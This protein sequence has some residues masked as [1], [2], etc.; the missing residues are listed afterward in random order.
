MYQIDR[1]ARTGAACGNPFIA[2]YASDRSRRRCGEAT[3]SSQCCMLLGPLPM[4]TA[5]VTEPAATRPIHERPSTRCSSPLQGFDLM[6]GSGTRPET[7]PP[8]WVTPADSIAS[9][10]A[11]NGDHRRQAESGSASAG[12]ARARPGPR[13]IAQRGR[14]RVRP[15]AERGQGKGAP[16]E[17][18]SISG[19]LSNDRFVA[20]RCA[21]I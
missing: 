10:P 8:T 21:A 17:R 6:I 15:V 2:V 12:L 9:S 3:A 5:Q 16:P 14:R 20:S 18:I 4:T 11:A 13:R 1:H 19:C 7:P